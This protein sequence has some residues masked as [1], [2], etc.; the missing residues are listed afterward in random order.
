VR[1][2]LGRAEM[3]VTEQQLDQANVGTIL[4]Q[5]SGK[6]MPQQVNGDMFFQAK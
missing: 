5:V 1:I 6:A 4:Q 3:V 2:Q